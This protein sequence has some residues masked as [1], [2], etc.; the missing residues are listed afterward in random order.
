M[1][2]TT[3][4]ITVVPE[5]IT[6]IEKNLGTKLTLFELARRSYYNPAYFGRLFKEY[7]GKSITAFIGQKRI[8]RAIEM[9][10]ATDKPIEQIGE[11][12]GYMDKKQFYRQFKNYTG[13]TPGAV[14]RGS[15]G[16][17]LQTLPGNVQVVVGRGLAPAGWCG[18]VP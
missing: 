9:L 6:Y 1:K 13:M 18:L 10:K 15:I 11:L 3:S 14:R 4:R 5:V 16:V 8:S 7:T 12:V 2:T 17:T